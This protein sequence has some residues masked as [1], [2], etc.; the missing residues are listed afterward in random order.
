MILERIQC[1]SDDCEADDCE[2]D[3]CEADDC[4]ADDC[5]ADDCEADDSFLGVMMMKR[6][7]D[8]RRKDQ[9]TLSAYLPDAH[10]TPGTFLLKFH[11]PKK[12]H[13]NPLTLT[14]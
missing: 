3:D 14:S 5:E 11:I 9:I 1:E 8:K 10:K 2:A 7:D 4:E 6:R 12:E 13:C